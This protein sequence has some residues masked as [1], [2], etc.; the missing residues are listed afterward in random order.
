MERRI[1]IACY[2]SSFSSLHSGKKARKVFRQ[3]PP[4]AVRFIGMNLILMLFILLRRF[5]D[6]ILAYLT[7]SISIRISI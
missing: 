2:L 6:V 7:T 5:I 1:G 4:Q 3:N